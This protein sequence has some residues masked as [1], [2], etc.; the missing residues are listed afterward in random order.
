MK[1][2]KILSVGI[3]KTS[4]DSK[5]WDEIKKLT[6]QL[7]LLPENSK[8]LKTHLKSTDCLLVYF[9]GVDKTMIDNTPNLKYIG[10]LATGVGKIDS[11]YAKQKGITVSNIPGYSTESVAELV[12]AVILEHIREI[13]R[14]KRESK[15]GNR[16]EVGFSAIEIKGK[17]FGILGLG[18]IGQRVAK[19]AESFGA[20]V[21]Y[22]SRN[23]KKKLEN[24]NIQFEDIDK[25]ISKCDFLSIHFAL[26]LETENILDAKRIAKIKKWAVVVNTAPMELVDINALEKRLKKGDITFIFD[27]TDLGDISEENLRRLQRYKNCI[28]YPVLGYI[29]KEARQTKQEM[30][31]ANI[32]DFLKGKP[33]NVVN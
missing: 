6:N 1:F 17:T 27:H 8:D 2:K 12:F 28:T 14:A 13:S 7:I 18:R 25:L 26:N 33:Q 30:F 24:K 23:R 9:N 22:W 3:S 32:K 29:S 21:L 15:E 19:L 16:S 11:K 5:Y 31:I 4:L 10:A 20:K